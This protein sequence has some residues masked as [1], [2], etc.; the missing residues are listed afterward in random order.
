[1]I[2]WSFQF[3]IYNIKLKGAKILNVNINIMFIITLKQLNI[4]F[5]VST[6]YLNELTEKLK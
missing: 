3:V 6:K 5:V 2:C 1:M 4:K